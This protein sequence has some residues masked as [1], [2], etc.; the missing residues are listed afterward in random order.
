MRRSERSD[1][2]KRRHGGAIVEF[3]IILPM[4]LL[5]ALSVFDIARAIQ[6]NM[7]L[8]SIGREGGSLASRSSGYSY[9][10]IMD[11]LAAT[12][13]PLEMNTQGMIYITR[14]MGRAESGVIRNIILEQYRWQQGW[15]QSQYTPLSNVWSCGASGGTS[16]ASDGSCAG[17]PSPGATSPTANAMTGMLKDGEVIFAVETYY[18]YQSLL[19][20]IG[21]GGGLMT[22]L[23]GPNLYALTIF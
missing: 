2:R 22:P 12:T 19:G 7:I 16:W 3:A 20:N 9:T 11:S 13:P 6:A 17:L 15:N 21:V 18:R 1:T 10:Q 4:I 14:I 23:V 8:V 5:M